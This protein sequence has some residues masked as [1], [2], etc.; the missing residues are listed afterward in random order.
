V[1]RVELKGLF[2]R[3][4]RLALTA[5]AIALG[6][7]LMAGT[8]IFTDTINASFDKIFQEGSKGTAVALTPHAA[9]G[10]TDETADSVSLPQSLLTRVEHLPGVHVAAGSIFSNGSIFDK[11][12]KRIG[13]GGAPNFVS[14]LSP[15]PLEGFT[16]ADGRMPRSADELAL[17]KSA[18]DRAGFHV[19]DRVDVQ[20]QAPRKSYRLVGTTTLGNASFGGATVATMTLP[21]A[22]RVVGKQGK[23]DQ[24]EIAAAPGVSPAQLKAE[25]RRA[26][27]ERTVNVRTGKEEAQNQSDQLRSNLGFLRTA[28]LAFAFISLFVGAFIIFNTFSITVAQ[29]TREFGLLR[30]LGA[31]RRQVMRAVLGESILLGLA[32]SV[33]GIVAGLG[34]APGLK[35][36][37]GAIGVDL[38]SNGLV[39]EPRTIVVSLV[40]GLLVTL[41]GGVAPALRATRVPP[42]AALREGVA[43][44]TTRT[45]RLMT[46]IAVL[47]TAL[48][49]VLLAVGLFAGLKSGPALTC[50]GLGSAAIFLGVALLSPRLVRPL[51]S[52]VGA[53]LERMSGITGRL[54]RENTTR[55]PGRTAVT[56]AA[57]MI[58]VTLVTF[59]S[60]FAAGAKTTI[61]QAVDNGLRSDLIV[62][63]TDGF[64]PYS[65]ET[66]PVLA[67]VAGVA[68]VS[69]V[70]FATAKVAGIAGDTSVTGIDPV[71]FAAMYH[72]GWQ[73]GDDGVLRAL[74]PGDVVVGKGYADK[75]ALHVGD[76]LRVLSPTGA[77]IAVTVRGILHDKGGM[78]G[79]LAMPNSV[80]EQTFGKR[81][82]ALTLVQYAPGANVAATQRAVKRTLARTFPSVE[83]QTNQQFKD[84]QAKQVNTLLGLFYALLALAIVVSLFG[85]VN[86]LV[87]SI[88]E[89]TRELGMLRAI[90]TSRRQVKRMVR[91]E[92]VITSLIGAV[93]G[94][95]LG[96]ALSVLVTKAIDDFSLSI[97]IGLLVAILIVAGLAGVG[98]AILPA[99]RASRLDVLESLA[100]E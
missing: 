24:I 29:R 41:L 62:M 80:L 18:A 5:F 94:L 35:A 90:G 14:S 15:A 45:G 63:S 69:P 4:M 60:V 84:Q 1:L 12:G 78:V 70:R 92:A 91:F 17:D 96:L 79:A 40:V 85:I 95:V 51:A 23:F 8:Y 97:P 75:H 32:G 22:Q 13:I 66:T 65:D 31:T 59:V 72:S 53:P 19:G 38:P 9:F 33:L 44:P 36:L 88:H 48:G 10:S 58:G 74:K 87:L 55:Q 26:V 37:M 82:D 11:K 99:R 2:A 56:A 49:V 27:P 42:I 50:V 43:L 39:V 61:D 30:T 20:G 6:V 7:T 25:V 83:A 52:L 57:L 68:S 86:T 54:A 34:V 71:T 46:P 21:E 64:S 77:S 100:Y 98:A 47:L 93:L 73:E 67:R 3:K 16:V 89:R 28:L 76:P 81:Q